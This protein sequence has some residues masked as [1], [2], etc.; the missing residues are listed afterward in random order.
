LNSLY[1]LTNAYLELLA[2]AEHYDEEALNDTLE[3]LTDGIEAKIENIVYVIRTIENNV[4]AITKEEKRLAEYKG[5]MNKTVKRLKEMIQNNVEVIGEKA[6]K[7]SSVTLKIGSPMLKA[8]RV[9]DNP[10][11]VK[12]NDEKAI[13]TSYYKPQPDKLDSKA[14]LADLKE[15]KKIAGAEM[16][17]TR[18]VRFS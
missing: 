18:G 9:Q 14:L 15:G 3:G 11:S 2:M 17:K 1:N 16:I 13:P 10:P 4:E 5:S 8:V 6:A 7:S 12:I